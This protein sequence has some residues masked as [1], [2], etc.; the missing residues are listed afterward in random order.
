MPLGTPNLLAIFALIESHLW[1]VY[2][3]I[4]SELIAMLYFDEMLVKAIL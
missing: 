3:H 1:Y 4:K 2:D